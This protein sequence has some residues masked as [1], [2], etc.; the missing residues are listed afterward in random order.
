M[1]SIHRLSRLPPQTSLQPMRS[2]RYASHSS[3]LSWALLFSLLLVGCSSNWTA[4]IPFLHRTD[5]EQGNAIDQ[6]LMDRIYVGMQKT[7]VKA[8]LGAPLVIDPFKPDRWEY[9]YTRIPADKSEPIYKRISVT[10]ANDHVVALGGTMEVKKDQARGVLQ[11]TSVQVITV[12]EKPE[13]GFWQ[14]FW[15]S[16]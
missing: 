9:V 13:K 15:D 6:Y 14:R 11:E 2:R 7:Q 5:L 10:F 12:P 16:D 1:R 4:H 3:P 8:I